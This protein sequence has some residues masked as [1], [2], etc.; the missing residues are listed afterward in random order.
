MNVIR[1]SP[2]VIVL[3][4]VRRAIARSGRWVEDTCPVLVE[5]TFL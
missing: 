4:I 1:I 3:D 2:D 5:M